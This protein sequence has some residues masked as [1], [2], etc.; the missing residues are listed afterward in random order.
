MFG[1]IAQRFLPELDR[2]LRALVDELPTAPEFDLMIRYACGW[3]NADGSAYD[4]PTGKRLRPLLL[5]MAAAAGGS[6]WHSALPAA[7]A[8]EFLH[9]FSL[10]HDD[11]QDNSPIRH[12][13]PTVWR[14]WG[15]A[16]AI[17]A[18]DAMFTLAYHAL[19]RLTDAQPASISPALAITIW[20]IFNHTNFELTRG[21]HLDMRF[22]QQ[23]HVTV[24]E[25][26]SMI[27]GKS[28]ALVAAS[29]QI[30]ALI[31][32]RRKRIAQAFYE[33]GLN[34][35]LA[36]QI[37]DDILGIWGDPAKTGKSAATD[38]LSRKKSF[39]VLYGLAESERLRHLYARESFGEDEVQ[40]AVS[41]LEEVGSRQFSL[42]AETRYYDQALAALNGSGLPASSTDDLR[43][44]TRFLFDREY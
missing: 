43:A 16:N 2:T 9:N 27:R 39:P 14:I 41:I 4:R 13:R 22:E 5:L 25:Y 29:T 28:A 17:N 36:F 15:I 19:E 42:D 18:G 26:L 24:E 33:Y 1:E 34:L 21:Q 7:A 32:S 40:E 3:V 23:M 10:I 30:G 37:H 8:V 6:D 35:G 44:I 38:I 20:R 12:G 31:G 11:I